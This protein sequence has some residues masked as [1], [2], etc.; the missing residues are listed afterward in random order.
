MIITA[1]E[2]NLIA[3]TPEKEC[4]ICEDLINHSIKNLDN[5]FLIPENY[6]ENDIGIR[7]HL[8]QLIGR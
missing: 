2:L 5:S 8:K 7:E 1:K 3:S 6:L 4:W